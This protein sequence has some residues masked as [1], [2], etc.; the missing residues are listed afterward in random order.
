MVVYYFIESKKSLKPIPGNAY[1]NVNNTHKAV[2]G[3]QAQ[4]GFDK[5]YLHHI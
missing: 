5:G 3:T 2:S 1:R 4:K